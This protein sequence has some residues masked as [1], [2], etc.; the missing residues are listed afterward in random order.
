LST[1]SKQRLGVS[2]ELNHPAFQTIRV[3]QVL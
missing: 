3:E 2:R 1:N